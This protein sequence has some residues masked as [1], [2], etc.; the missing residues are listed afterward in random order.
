MNNQ[1]I[2]YLIKHNRSYTKPMYR[3]LRAKEQGLSLNKFRKLL[4]QMSIND[5]I[6]CNVETE[7]DLPYWSSK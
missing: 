4:Y 5:E 1:I 2:I 7:T 3:E 6:V